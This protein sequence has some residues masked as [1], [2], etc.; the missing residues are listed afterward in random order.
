M[1]L[2]TL[3]SQSQSK[4]FYIF[5]TACFGGRNVSTGFCVFHVAWSNPAR[6][7]LVRYIKRQGDSNNPRTEDNQKA[8]T[9]IVAF[10]FLFSPQKFNVQTTTCFIRRN[11]SEPQNTISI[12][13][14]EWDEYK[15]ESSPQHNELKHVDSGSTAVIAALP[16]VKQQNS[17]SA[18]VRV[19]SFKRMS[20]Y[21]NVLQGRNKLD[22]SVL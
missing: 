1:V 6:F 17:P 15:T 18:E 4:Q 2:A 20:L 22:D 5:F 9:H 10:F 21:H 14:F 12:I 3:Y 13:F 7:L 8:S 19:R 16:D 11:A